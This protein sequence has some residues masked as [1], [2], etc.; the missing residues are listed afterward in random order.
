[1]R[2]FVQKASRVNAPWLWDSLQGDRNNPG[3][4]HVPA[5]S[6]FTDRDSPCYRVE[7]SNSAQKQPFER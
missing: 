7:V 3:G 4:L 5:R 2:A 6:P 1:M